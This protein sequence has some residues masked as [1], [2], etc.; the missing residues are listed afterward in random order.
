MQRHA[1]YLDARGGGQETPIKAP[2][3]LAKLHMMLSALDGDGCL[4]A[5]Q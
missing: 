5:L 4:H 2:Q 1:R 3:S